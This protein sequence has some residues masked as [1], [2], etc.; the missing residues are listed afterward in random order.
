MPDPAILLTCPHCGFAK[1]VPTSRLPVRALRV[2]CPKCGGG[3]RLP[4][5]DERNLPPVPA[6]LAGMPAGTAVGTE[7]LPKAGYWIRFV[8]FGIDTLVVLLV[9]GVLAL[10]MGLTI[11]AVGRG[12]PEA[13]FAMGWLATLVSLMIGTVYYVFFTGYGGQTPGKMATGIRVICCDG[14][15]VGFG[16]AFFREVFGKFISGLLLGAGYLMIAFDRQKQGLHDK[17][18]DTFV[19]RL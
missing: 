7:E 6:T 15:E 3:F 1:P 14:G 2:T 8:A 16:R 4:T 13:I 10:A 11:G 19:I 12:N 17:I 5:A 9:Q 18:A